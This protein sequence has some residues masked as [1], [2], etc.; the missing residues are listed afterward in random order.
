MTQVNTVP[1]ALFR[2]GVLVAT[3]NCLEQISHEAR[4]IALGRHVRGD[5]GSVDAEDK[6]MNNDSLKTGGRLLSV[7]EEKGK[8]FW[9]ITEADRSSTCILMPE[10]Y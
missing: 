3:P 7:Y 6:H 4:M 5:W 8:K 10:D 2:I 1:K 9:I